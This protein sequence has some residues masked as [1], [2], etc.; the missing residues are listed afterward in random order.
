MLLFLVAAALAT[1]R[2]WPREPAAALPREGARFPR[3]VLPVTGVAAAVAVAFVVLTAHSDRAALNAWI[4]PKV[5]TYVHNARAEVR[6]A[7]AHGPVVILDRPVPNEVVGAFLD[8]WN[9]SS[10]VMPTLGLNRLKFGTR[11]D[12]LMQ[13]DNDGHLVRVGF[14]PAAAAA[15]GITDGNLVPQGKRRCA[16]GPTAL[17]LAAPKLLQ[18][19]NTDLRFVGTASRGASIP[20]TVDTDG[21]GFP[22]FV[23]GTLPV[24]AGPTSAALDLSNSIAKLRLDIPPGVVL[25]VRSAGLGRYAPVGSA[26]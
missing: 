3:S 24:S 15:T 8:P 25:C 22:A 2:T 7:E 4:G 23:K 10:V 14:K 1:S 21:N 6:A 20:V 13:I 12:G 19:P 5:R 26:R 11:A 16:A 17:V 18:A 9:R